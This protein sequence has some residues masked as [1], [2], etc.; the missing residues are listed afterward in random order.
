MFDSFVSVAR[1]ILLAALVTL[2]IQLT[3]SS[4]RISD[5]RDPA[6]KYEEG[7]TNLFNGKDLSGWVPVL[8]TS[9]GSHKRY[10]EDEHD[11]QTT[12]YVEDGMIKTTGTPNGYIRTNDVY[13]NFVFHV[14]VRF[15]ESGNSGVLIHVQRDAVWPRGIECQLYQSHMGRIFPILGATLNGGEMIHEAANPPGQWNTYEVYS[16]EGRVAT[17]LN[18]KLVGL[19]SDA[20][21]RVGYICLQSEGVPAEFRNIKVRRYTPKYHLRNAPRD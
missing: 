21:P 10:Q 20:D 11:Q 1:M 14:E 12:F 4:Q 5:Y 16:E 2:G 19:A 7:W 3:V 17:V 8:R 15:P 9:D 18:G 6:V 13:D